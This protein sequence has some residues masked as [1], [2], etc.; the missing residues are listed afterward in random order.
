MDALGGL[1]NAEA[2][3]DPEKVNAMREHLEGLDKYELALLKWRLDWNRTARP[4]QL[5]PQGDWNTWGAMAGRGWGKTRV[6]ANWIG[7]EAASDPGSF[8]G[9][10]APTRDDVR[11]VCFEGETGIFAYLPEILIADYNKSDLIIYLWNGSIIRG[12]GSERPERLRGPQHHRVWC[13]ELA[14]WQYARKCWDMMQF[15]L[16]LGQQTRCV[17][18]TTPKPVPIIKDRVLEQDAKHII[19]RGSTYENR[20]NLSEKFYEE[21]AKYEGT[22]LGRQELHGE[23][24]DPEESGIVKRSQWRLW[25]AK[26]KL[27]RFIHIV[28]S[29]DTA[30]TE[31]TFDKQELSADPTASGTWGL[32]YHNKM[33]NVMLLDAWDD[34]L[35]LPKLIDTVRK[36]SQIYYGQADEALIT[37]MIVPSAYQLSQQGVMVGRNS[38]VILVEDKGSG[39]SLRQMLGMENL[40][41]TPYNPGR[42]DKLARLHEVT[43]MFAHG[44]VWAVESEKRPGEPRNWADGL[45]SQVC[46]YHGP[47]TTEHD[48]YVDLTTQAMRYF[49]RRFIHTFVEPT[50][51]EI[52]EREENER[53]GTARKGGGSNPYD[54]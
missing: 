35:G 43:P 38:D 26:Q 3:L 31:K 48:D 29:L 42:A 15:G 49:M 53:F 37:P 1:F 14:A 46:S 51:E 30:F 50:K 13:D 17:W 28:M 2:A 19:T 36:E 52:Q 9:V 41:L 16:R 22:K 21:V 10:I 47:G 25:P 27:P 45:I 7:I 6:G 39:I 34:H 44:R 4:S 20:A 40:L 33:L 23:L 32:F 12:F 8:S 18:T 5:V 24:I 54:S 11:Y